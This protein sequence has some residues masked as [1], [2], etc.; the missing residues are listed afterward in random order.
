[1]DD[2]NYWGVNSINY[3]TDGG[4]TK[5]RQKVDLVNNFSGIIIDSKIQKYSNQAKSGC[6]ILKVPP[7]DFDTVLL[8]IKELGEVEL[9]RVT[10]EDITEEY[11][12]LGARLKNAEVV[13]DRLLKI[14]E[15]RAREVKDILEVER[16][17]ARIGETIEQIKGRMKYL[18]RQVDLATITVNYYEPKAMAPE[19]LN[20][21]KRLKETIRTAI[22][23]FI[24]VFNGAIV[25][26]AAMLPI[27]IWL[28][29]IG[30]VV[31]VIKR[32]FRK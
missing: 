13:R 3:R 14:L 5:L 23:A 31:I 6:T 26:I 1:M 12:D 20:V 30:I 7:K 8:K 18:D 4:D 17:L 21:V 16:E 22:E 15:E 28:A 25:I 19:P 24:N 11:I 9:E 32:L 27:I 2:G 29:I 10:G